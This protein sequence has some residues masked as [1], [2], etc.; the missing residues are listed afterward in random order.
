MASETRR[1]RK[2]VLLVIS[3]PG[4]SKKALVWSFQPLELAKERCFDRSRRW[5]WQKNV[6]WVPPKIGNDQ[7]KPNSIIIY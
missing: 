7:T 3:A 2:N 1:H 4:T 5:R 6:G